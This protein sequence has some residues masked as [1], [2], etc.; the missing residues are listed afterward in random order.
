MEMTRE[1]AEVAA[2]FADMLLKI[3]DGMMLVRP[4]I[5]GWLA[6]IDGDDE[7]LVAFVEDQLLAGG[8]GDMIEALAIVNDAVVTQIANFAARVEGGQDE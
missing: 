5:K 1:Q 4:A 3:D 2:G 8:A 7:E 6:M